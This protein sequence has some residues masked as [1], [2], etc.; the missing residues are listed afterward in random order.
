MND[1]SQL[2]L[3]EQHSS[4]SQRR[5]GRKKRIPTAEHWSVLNFFCS[6]VNYRK[7]KT[8][9]KETT[10]NRQNVVIKS[11]KCGDK[12]FFEHVFLRFVS[13]RERGGCQDFAKGMLKVTTV[14]Y[15]AL[16]GKRHTERQS[17]RGA[18]GITKELAAMRYR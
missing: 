18:L 7:R 10:G 11:T 4:K 5:V 1:L 14:V 9:E 13:I 15:N 2:T 3:T 8:F 16:D 12:T 6:I 17:S